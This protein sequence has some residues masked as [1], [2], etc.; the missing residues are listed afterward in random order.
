M[1]PSHAGVTSNGR[2]LEPLSMSSAGTYIAKRWWSETFLFSPP[3][4]LHVGPDGKH[5]SSLVY[6]L[7]G[8]YVCMPTVQIGAPYSP[9][10]TGKAA[11]TQSSKYSR[12][13]KSGNRRPVEAGSVV[14]GVE[15][16]PRGG[17][18]HLDEVLLGRSGSV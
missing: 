17:G 16:P 6:K 9:V 7:P 13:S 5:T 4:L 14:R 11:I 18:A 10:G 15:T 3:G 2:P 12:V 8:E 1:H